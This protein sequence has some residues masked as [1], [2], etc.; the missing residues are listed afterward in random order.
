MARWREAALRVKENPEDSTCML[1]AVEMRLKG[2]EHL[3]PFI[4]LIGDPHEDPFVKVMAVE[5]LEGQAHPMLIPPLLP[6]TGEDHDATTRACATHVLGM[7]WTPQVQA[8]LKKLADDPERRV[9]FAALRG[10]AKHG[11]RQARERFRELYS[12]PGVTVQERNVIASVFA[13]DIG[14]DAENVPIM[15]KVVQDMELAAMVRRLAVAALGRSRDPAAVPALEKAAEASPEEDIREIAGAAMRLC[16]RPPA[17]DEG[18]QA[19][20][21]GQDDA[22]VSLVGP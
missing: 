11:D 1:M 2:P 13:N 15:C 12:E 9:R 7:L 20:V 22:N 19:S 8:L 5:A 6:L 4:D 18:N 14:R 16:Q 3:L 17:P 21:S 10:L